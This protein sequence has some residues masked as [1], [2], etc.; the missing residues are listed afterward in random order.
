MEKAGRIREYIARHFYVANPAELAED[1][2]LLEQGIIDST[3]A[4]ELISFLEHE[5]AIQ[6]ADAE[7]V[8]E[9]LDSI[10]R[11]AAYVTRKKS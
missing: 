11:I 1:S 9:N 5:F 2:S 10:A 4:L 3:G 8:P 7:M 6:V